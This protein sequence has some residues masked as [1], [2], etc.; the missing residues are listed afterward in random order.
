ME[1]TC[2]KIQLLVPNISEL[3]DF[4][5]AYG[6]KSWEQ[7]NDFLLYELPEHQIKQITGV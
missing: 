5:D 1:N 4:V 2:K 3:M 7:N 6:F